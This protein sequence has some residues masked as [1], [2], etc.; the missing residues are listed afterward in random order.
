MEQEHH[1]KIA[2]YPGSFDPLTNGHLDIIRRASK[3]FDFL[4][5]GV[6]NNSAKNPLFTKEERVSMIQKCTGEIENIEVK[7]FNGLLVDFVKENNAVAIVK[8]LR[9]VSDYEYELQMAALNKHIAEEIETIFFMANI[10]N[11]FLSSS[12]VKELARNGGNIQG[13]VP[14]KIIGD[15]MAKMY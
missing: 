10:Q 15:I 12:I 7:M 6:L 13:L 5:V 4:I 11:S 3:L 8:G 1:V 14:D 9:A 2:V